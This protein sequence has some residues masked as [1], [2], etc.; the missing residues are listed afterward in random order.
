MANMK[1]NGIDIITPGQLKTYRNTALS[2]TPQ[3]ISSS[4]CMVFSWTLFNLNDSTVYLKFYNEASP[5]VGTDT[6]LAV[7][8]IPPGDGTNPGIYIDDN[9]G[10]FRAFNALAIA[11]VTGL[12]DNDATT[13][14]TPIYAEII[15]G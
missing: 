6:P 8:P 12:S 5:T 10:S 14:T 9:N 11:A 7:L 15:W 1:T 13:P 2:S 3:A 4:S